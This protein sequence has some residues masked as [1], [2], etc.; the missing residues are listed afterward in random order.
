MLDN[1]MFPNQGTDDEM[2]AI[3]QDEIF[4]FQLLIY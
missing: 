1:L 3:L 4:L 2:A